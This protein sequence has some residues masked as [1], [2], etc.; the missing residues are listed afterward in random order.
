M[1]LI[2]AFNRRRDSWR[3]G[4]VST[5]IPPLSCAMYMDGDCL[6]E[7]HIVSDA[8]RIRGLTPTRSPMRRASH[9]ANDYYRRVLVVDR[10]R[11]HF[12]LRLKRFVLLTRVKFR[13]TLRGALDDFLA[14]FALIGLLLLRVA[15]GHV[16]PLSEELK[17]E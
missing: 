1:N 2:N 12:G 17:C 6:I 10:H 16:G 3:A 8:G 15:F 4:C 7:I 5:L 11:R 9:D 14:G 13:L